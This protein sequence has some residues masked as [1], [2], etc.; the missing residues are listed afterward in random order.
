MLSDFSEFCLAMHFVESL[1]S[2][3]EQ[4]RRLLVSELA[5]NT[6]YRDDLG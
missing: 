5:L 1:C 6:S 3:M 2:C 4:H